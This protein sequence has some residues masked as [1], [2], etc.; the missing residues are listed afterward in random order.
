VS[1]QV[2]VAGSLP[3]TGLG[4]VDKAA[5]CLIGKIFAKSLLAGFFVC[6]IHP[7]G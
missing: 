3:L 2:I 6:L 7:A 1:K 4:K 5:E